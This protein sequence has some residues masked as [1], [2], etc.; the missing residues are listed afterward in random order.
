MH[1]K[2][3]A[4]FQKGQVNSTQVPILLIN[5]HYRAINVNIYKFTRS[6]EAWGFFWQECQERRPLPAET[7]RKAR[8][9]FLWFWTPF[10]ALMF[11]SWVLGALGKGPALKTH[12]SR[13]LCSRNAT[14]TKVSWKFCLGEEK[15]KQVIWK[16]RREGEEIGPMWQTSSGLSCGDQLVHLTGLSWVSNETLDVNVQVAGCQVL[17][18]YELYSA[19]CVVSS[20]KIRIVLFPF[21]GS[22]KDFLHSTSHKIGFQTFMCWLNGYIRTRENLH[23]PDAKTYA[24][25]FPHPLS[26]LRK[27]LRKNK[28][29]EWYFYEDFYVAP[30][31]TTLRRNNHLSRMTW[32]SI[33]PNPRSE[34]EE[35]GETIP[36][37]M[38]TKS[39]RG[40]NGEGAAAYGPT[41]YR[42]S[43]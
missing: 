19:Q 10:Q 12:P 30:P 39:W 4:Y 7:S 17:E 1:L 32:I 9:H 25:L 11:H 14:M 5:S 33:C 41:I 18:K 22:P 13:G 42:W 29:R 28:M 23:P 8:Q 21:L 24:R 20:L 35:D 40:R 6:L 43:L 37:M 2:I 27:L 26:L 16:G 3:E 15:L 34:Q 31:H 36:A 38:E